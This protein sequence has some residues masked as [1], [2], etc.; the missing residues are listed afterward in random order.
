MQDKINGLNG[1]TKFKVEGSRTNGGE[2][3]YHEHPETH[4]LIIVNTICVPNGE[5]DVDF[6]SEVVEVHSPIICKI[7]KEIEIIKNKIKEL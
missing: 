2:T 4:E 1:R 3:E 6:E 7:I 5:D